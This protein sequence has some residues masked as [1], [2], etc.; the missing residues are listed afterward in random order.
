MISNMFFIKLNQIYRRR[1]SL[2]FTFVN[3]CTCLIQIGENHQADLLLP[4]QNGL[5]CLSVA[6][7]FT[8]SKH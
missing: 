5:S 2:L 7:I 1:I 4:F 8:P 3:F 6:V